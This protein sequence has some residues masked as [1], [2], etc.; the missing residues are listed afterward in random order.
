MPSQSHELCNIETRWVRLEV[1]VAQSML[2]CVATLPFYPHLQSTVLDPCSSC[3]LNG[4]SDNMNNVHVVWACTPAHT[5][6]WS[7][8]YAHGI[9][10]NFTGISMQFILSCGWISVHNVFTLT[11]TFLG[12]IYSNS[13]CML[14]AWLLVLI[15]L[16]VICR[17]LL[18]KWWIGLMVSNYGNFAKRNMSPY[19]SGEGN[20]V[21]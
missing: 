16:L 10:G 21:I 20:T 3:H 6:N 9:D 8:C 5:N 12:L 7:Y 2:I 15:T 18:M 4:T 11:R 19:G 14:F 17:E 1:G 13:L